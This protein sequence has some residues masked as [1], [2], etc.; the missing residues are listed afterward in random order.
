MRVDVRGIAGRF[1]AAWAKLELAVPRHPKAYAIVLGVSTIAFFSALDVLLRII[2][3]AALAMTE[4]GFYLLVT[5]II[6]LFLDEIGFS[7]LLAKLKRN[8]T[9]E[10]GEGDLEAEGV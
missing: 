7:R 3:S 5:A 8:V 2:H 10:D 9:R 1:A 4:W 6:I